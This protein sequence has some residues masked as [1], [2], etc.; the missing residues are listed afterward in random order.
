MAVRPTAWARRATSSG[1]LAPSDA[2]EWQWRST[3]AV[4]AL[5]RGPRG[6]RLPEQLEQ[7]AGR[8]LLQRRIDA[9]D[10]GRRVAGEAPFALRPGPELEHQAVL[11]LAVYGDPPRGVDLP[12][13]PIHRQQSARHRSGLGRCLERHL[14]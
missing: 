7:L 9:P 8:E 6:L 5:R 4:G 14:S 11:V 1:A 3:C 13:L 10:A 12:R 2:V